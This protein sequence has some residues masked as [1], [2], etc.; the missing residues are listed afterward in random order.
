MLSSGHPTLELNRAFCTRLK[1]MIVPNHICQIY[2]PLVL[3]VSMRFST[4]YGLFICS[5]TV[6]D[7]SRM[8]DE[9]ETDTYEELKVKYC[10]D[11]NTT[12]ATLGEGLAVSVFPRY[13]P[14]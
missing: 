14:V 13:V 3:S 5:F 9:I 12:R 1:L 4:H 6:T 10:R 8:W 7:I 2:Y 11:R